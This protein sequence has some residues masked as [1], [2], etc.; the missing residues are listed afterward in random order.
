LF[1]LILLKVHSTQIETMVSSLNK[2]SEYNRHV[3]FFFDFGSDNFTLGDVSA[4]K[5]E[6]RFTSYSNIYLFWI[7]R[8]FVAAR[9]RTH[10]TWRKVGRWLSTQPTELN[11]RHSLLKRF[12]ESSFSVYEFFITYCID[13]VFYVEWLYFTVRK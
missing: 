4:F 1:Y 12:Y 9:N 2:I 8:I 3:L 10:A 5:I 6:R 11:S 13:F 7:F